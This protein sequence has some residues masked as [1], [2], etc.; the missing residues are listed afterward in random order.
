MHGTARLWHLLT[1]VDRGAVSGG[2]FRLHTLLRAADLA[3]WERQNRLV[4]AGYIVL[5]FTWDDLRDR[6]A[7]VIADIRR[8]LAMAVA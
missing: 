8:S 6:P 1:L 2:E 7:Q 3:G 5:R 4:A